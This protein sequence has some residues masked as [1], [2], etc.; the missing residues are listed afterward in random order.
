MMSSTTN[1]L[2][3]RINWDKRIQRAAELRQRPSS[4]HQV[5]GFYEHVLGVQQR[6]FQDLAGADPIPQPSEA[7]RE[8]IEIDRAMTW[9]PVVFELVRS[10]GPAKLAAEAERLAASTVEYRRQLLRDSLNSPQ[11]DGDE[12]SSFFARV[13]LQPAAE[14][15]AAQ[16]TVPLTTSET[17]CPLCGSK[18]QLAILRPEGDGGKRHLVCSFCAAEWEFRRVLCPVCGETDYTKLPR[19]LPEEPMAVRVEACDTCKFYLKSFDMTE[20]G[21]LVPE[22]DEVATIALDLWA[23]EHG[24]Q[25]I[26]ANVM[27]F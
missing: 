12:A 18:P 21:M 6:I 20:D 16:M 14:F 11:G 27:G 19:Y 8:N 25:K 5:L 7:F 2:M 24:Y 3:N 15:L 26:R 9:L 10:K 22:V 1:K 13:V 17:V 4:P 23:S